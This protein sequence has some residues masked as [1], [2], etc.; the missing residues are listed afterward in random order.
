VVV[1]DHRQGHVDAGGD[2]RR[3]PDPAVADEDGF[4]IDLDPRIGASQA[5]ARRPVGGGALAVEDTGARG[6][7][8][9]VANRADAA[10]DARGAELGNPM[11]SRD[12]R[13]S[14]ALRALR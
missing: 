14:R 5:V 10:D 4:A 7:E 3:R 12:R 1:L 9:P 6:E 8:C 11:R 13:S 2:A